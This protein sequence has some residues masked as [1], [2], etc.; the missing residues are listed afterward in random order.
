[1]GRRAFI[2]SVAAL[3]AAGSSFAQDAQGPRLAAIDWAML[4]TAI[5]IGQMPVAACELIRYRQDEAAEAIPQSVTDLGLRGAPNYE[6]LQLTRPDLILSSPF[7]IQHEAR[8]RAIAP[9]LSLPFYVPGEPPVA[10]TLAATAALAEAV[11][12]P[13]V[14]VRVETEAQDRIRSLASRLAPFRDR[15]VSLIN[16]GDSRH[17]RAFGFDSLFGD[18]LGR[19]GLANAWTDR[20]QFSFRAPLPIERLADAPE[21]RLIIVGQIPVEAREGVARSV[22]WRKLPAVAEGRLYQLPEVNAFGGLPSALRFAE[23]LTGA[24]EA[25]PQ[26]A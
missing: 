22:L 7:Y 18:M 5:A 10:K 8:L 4:E 17:L 20:T 26:P 9:V 12:Q 16:I 21:A 11:G 15:P 19:L 25:G 1:M 2:S 6:L 23:M 24:L 13:E 14:A 3:A